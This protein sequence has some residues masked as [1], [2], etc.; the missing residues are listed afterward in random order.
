MSEYR[1]GQRAGAGSRY[2]SGTTAWLGAA[3]WL[4]LAA[5]P[6]FALM[7]LLTVAH[8]G[9]AHDPLCTAAHGG[10]PVSGMVPMYVLM[11]AFHSRP[12]LN[13]IASRGPSA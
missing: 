9:G 13:L 3:D 6:V 11:S 5:A 1:I 2:E 4:S 8:G 7:A 12:W 10:S